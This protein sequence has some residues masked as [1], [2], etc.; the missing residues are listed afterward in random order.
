MHERILNLTEDR[1]AFR[2]VVVDRNERQETAEARTDGLQDRVAILE[3]E[4][5]RLRERC[6]ELE[7]DDRYNALEVENHRL[8]A[9]LEKYGGHEGRCAGRQWAPPK[10]DVECTCG[11]TAALTERREGNR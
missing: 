10:A 11:F 6:R 7:F 9:A 5:A 8:R 4:N 2:D 3:A 1:N